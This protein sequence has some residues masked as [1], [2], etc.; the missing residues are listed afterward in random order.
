MRGIVSIL[1]AT[2]AVVLSST[3]ADAAVT[4]ITPTLHPPGTTFLVSGNPFTG[5]DPLS[6]IIGHTGI[7]S[8][9]FEDIYRFT[10]GVL[11]QGQIGT[12][13][14]GITTNI[15]IG[16]IGGRTDVDFTKVL[17]NGMF[18]TGTYTDLH[19]NACITPHVGTCGA[20]ETFTIS[21]VPI[22]GG[23]LNEIDVYGKVGGPKRGIGSY[24]GS[25]TFLPL[26]EPTTWAMMLLGFGAVGFGARRK[27]NR[28]LLE[29][30]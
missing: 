20:G 15:T 30:A 6:A 21:G 4:I 7:P 28:A 8:G 11:G 22:M 14:G 5:T 27:R 2:A 26:P 19:G 17:V 25:A 24:G 10:I 9:P 29:V 3:T 16:G 12:A 1:A 18:A 23:V 13:S